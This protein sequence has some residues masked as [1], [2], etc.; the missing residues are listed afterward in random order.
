MKIKQVSD[1]HHPLGARKLLCRQGQ[2]Y[3]LAQAA[4]TIVDALARFEGTQLLIQDN[5]GQ[6]GCVLLTPQFVDMST[7]QIIRFGQQ[8]Q[9]PAER[10]NDM[11]AI[12]AA[13][14]E[15]LQQIEHDLAELPT[16]MRLEVVV[17]VSSEPPKSRIR[18]I[19]LSSHSTSV[20]SPKP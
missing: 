13:L 15:V 9:I 19:T 3:D 12:E 16:G 17:G 8:L 14:P 20:S 1:I 6:L 2:Q 7:M 11:A 10:Y 4:S 5:G 18:P